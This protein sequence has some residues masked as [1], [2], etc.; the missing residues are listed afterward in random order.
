[1]TAPLDLARE[2]GM[3]MRG[4]NTRAQSI[5]QYAERVGN[6]HDIYRAGRA[7]VHALVKQLGGELRIAGDE[8]VRLAIAPEEECRFSVFLPRSTS[9]RADR[10]TIA[11]A[12]GHLFLHYL[13]PESRG[14]RGI[15]S[16]GWE[17]ATGMTAEARLFG[18]ALLV[19]PDAA[20]TLLFLSGN[21]TAYVA[22]HYGVDE[23]IVARALGLN[24]R[25]LDM[26]PAGADSA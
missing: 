17:T 18:Q 14:E 3:K 1:M 19:P 16:F 20:G 24:D 8:G 26:N 12:L 25:I 7:D 6:E 15:K 5:R 10:L 2:P 13:V 9:F 11:R 22:H 4:T 21:D 23:F